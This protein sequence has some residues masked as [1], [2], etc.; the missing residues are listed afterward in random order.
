MGASGSFFEAKHA[1]NHVK[2]QRES[3]S[4]AQ[5]KPHCAGKTTHKG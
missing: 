3:A 1:P 4:R 5:A 2:A